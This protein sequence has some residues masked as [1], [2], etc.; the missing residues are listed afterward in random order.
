MSVAE[1]MQPMTGICFWFGMRFQASALPELVGPN[2]ATTC[3][4]SIRSLMFWIDFGG[5]ER[6]S[7]ITNVN[8]RPSTPPS[9]LR[10]SI[11]A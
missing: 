7:R 5:C 11:A 4:L 2:T 9:A 8:G 3:S 6:S 10:S 1:P